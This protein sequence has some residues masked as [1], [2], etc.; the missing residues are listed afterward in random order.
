MA[1]AAKGSKSE[2]TPIAEDANWKTNCA[3]EE[4]IRLKWPGKYG[5]M[6]GAY[7]ELQQNQKDLMASRTSYGH[8]AHPKMTEYGINFGADDNVRADATSMAATVAGNATTNKSNMKMTTSGQYGALAPI[9]TFAMGRVTRGKRDV[10]KS[11]DWPHGS[12]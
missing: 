4:Q 3:K 9:E 11:F 12:I 6:P 1:D 10:E 2:I 8:G 7:E 5:H